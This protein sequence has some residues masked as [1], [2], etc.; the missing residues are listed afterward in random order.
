ML[1]FVA[2]TL[3]AVTNGV[4]YF[5]SASV[6]GSTYQVAIGDSTTTVSATIP[7]SAW[8]GI[9][10]GAS[11]MADTVVVIFEGSTDA[12]SMR[13]L[14]ASSGEAPAGTLLDYD[15]WTIT[16]K[17]VS[18]GILSFVMTRDNDVSATCA[19]C[20]TFSSSSTTLNVIVAQGSSTE[21]AF[22]SSKASL[23]LSDT[24]P[25]SLDFEEC[26]TS[27]AAELGGT[28]TISVSM[29][30][31]SAFQYMKLTLSASDDY[32]WFGVGFGSKSMSGTYAILSTDSTEGGMM[33]CT[34]A[35]SEI[36]RTDPDTWNPDEPCSE[37]SPN[38]WSYDDGEVN[39]EVADGTRTIEIYRPYNPSD[40]TFDFTDFMDATDTSL[41]IISAIGLDADLT[42]GHSTVN[43]DNVVNSD[44][45]GF[46]TIV[47]QCSD[48]STPSPVTPGDNTGSG[49]NAISCMVAV[50]AGV[51]AYVAA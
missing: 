29:S 18:S 19:E 35:A 39:I 11:S 51:A 36:L 34:L 28:G 43:D 33:E 24:S 44:N 32:P 2:S 40:D 47:T 20:Y 37:I 49:A 21:F 8:A 17:S 14:G 22:H 45:R 15:L 1:A 50:L 7:T 16:K 9:G 42:L 10:F 48:G 6:G 25:T 5:G 31:N 4:T 41:D 12:M 46:T 30:R 3:F 38:S 23:S 26:V 13:Q 27:A